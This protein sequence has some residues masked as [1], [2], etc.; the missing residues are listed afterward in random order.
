MIYMA[1]ESPASTSVHPILI[2]EQGEPKINI[3]LA[4]NHEEMV[5]LMALDMTKLPGL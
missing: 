3:N 1:C 4:G 5:R 2:C